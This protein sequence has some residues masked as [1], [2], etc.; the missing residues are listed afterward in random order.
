MDKNKLKG[1]KKKEKA[2][3]ILF[4]LQISF[5]PITTLSKGASQ[6]HD[7]II[8]LHDWNKSPGS[9]ATIIEWFVE[10]GW[11]DESLIANKFANPADTSTAG[12]IENANAIKNWVNTILSDTGAEKVD[13]VSSGMGS[14]SSLYYIKFLDGIDKVDDYVSVGGT[15]AVTASHYDPELNT[16]LGNLTEGDTTPGGILNDTDEGYHIPGN[17]SYTSIYS[18]SQTWVPYQC[19]ILDGANNIAIKDID[20]SRL[21]VNDTVYELVKT[22]VNGEIA[23]GISIEYF[24]PTIALLVVSAFGIERKKKKKK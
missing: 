14:M 11:S 20:Y 19:S 9:W 21:L 16:L 23:K 3:L 7:P 22:A 6:S 4:L 1:L 18:I 15:H 5:V 10:D 13:L 8:F 2:I 24:V 12:N 17:I